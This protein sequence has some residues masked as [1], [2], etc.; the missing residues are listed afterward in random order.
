MSY[1]K[2]L[3][4]EILNELEYRKLHKKEW[5]AVEITHSICEKHSD[6]IIDGSEF[7]EYNVFS[8]VKREVKTAINKLAGEKP[9][10]D[11]LQMVMPGFEHLQVYYLVKRD[12]RI[13]GV[14]I[15]D[16]SDSEIDEK[17][18]RYKKMGESC[19]K[20]A[21]ELTGYKQKRNIIVNQ[22]TTV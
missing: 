7:T 3:T 18:S 10:Q 20:H 11:N 8:N 12:D 21:D 14:H 6:E 22:K 16:M 15:D 5:D 1:K 2:V 19:Y 4:N 9:E 17:V 13:M